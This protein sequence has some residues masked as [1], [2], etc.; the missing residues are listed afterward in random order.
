MPHSV[1]RLPSPA[2]E[3]DW[4]AHDQ[5]RCNGL[6]V[7][8]LGP[9]RLGATW[10]RIAP[11]AHQHRHF[12]HLRWTV[13]VHERFARVLCHPRV[14]AIAV[15]TEVGKRLPVELA[16]GYQS[17]YELLVHLCRRCL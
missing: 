16:G 5:K 13:G 15:R 1:V 8:L 11:R 3:G 7:R 17:T 6:I 4:R 12:L 9:I 10:R 2:E 14:S